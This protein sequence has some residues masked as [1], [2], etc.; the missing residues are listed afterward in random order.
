MV[1]PA[2]DREALEQAIAR[3][4]ELL[5]Q[6]QLDQAQRAFRA[7]LE[8][9]PDNARVLALLGLSHFRAGEFGDARPIYEDL[10]DR[11]PTDASH[12]LNL[13][14]VYLKLSDSDRAIDALEASRA[15][16]PS[17]GRAV[18]Y[19]GLAY[20]RAGRY[21]EAYRSFLLAGQNDLASEIEGN[22]TAAE[23]DGIHGQ[24]GRTPAGPLAEVAVPRT[25]TPPPMAGSGPIPIPGRTPT[26][27]PSAGSGPIPVAARTI[28]PHVIARTPT[29][30]HGSAP[31]NTPGNT[32]GEPRTRPPR[33][34]PKTTDRHDL[35]EL[36]ARSRPSEPQLSHPEITI[37]ESSGPRAL[38][39]AATPEAIGHD[40]PTTPSNVRGAPRVTDSVQFV[41]P[42]ASA[43]PQ[44]VAGQS[45]L[46]MAV[47]AAEPLAAV[48]TARTASGGIPPRPLSEI[49]TEELVRPDDG[50]D[51]FEI[52]AGGALVIRVTDRVLTRLDGVHVTG[53][54]L[55]YEPAMRRSR[56]HQTDERFDFGTSP[57]HVVSG[58]G[59]LIAARGARDFT[60]IAL[61]DD[62]LY[63]REDLVFAFEAGLRWENGNVPGLRGRLHVVQFRGDGAL[64]LRLARPLVRVK[65]PAQGLVFVDA[66]RLAGWI[67]RVIPRAVV[68]PGGGPLGTMCVE[69]TGEG[70]VL[71]EPAPEAGVPAAAPPP[72]PEPPP[73]PAV[74][75]A[76]PTPSIPPELADFAAGLA[77]DDEI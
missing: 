68:P 38:A 66:E 34:A 71:V 56:G 74:E 69:C 62:I 70:V 20:A 43:V 25:M 11:A 54:D 60:A 18:S 27:P 77:H 65:L 53:G 52:A 48:T 1:I 10:V 42:K 40:T 47:A 26:P 75:E 67:G 44:P 19:L 3:G 12:R 36:A 41:L 2:R 61:D 13:G 50:A 4:S 55:A 6:S 35:S 45:M 46:S 30:Q 7:A 29:P 39:D 33:P 31:G 76:T 63:V 49:A 72:A 16:D 57:L 9:D 73:A 51:P 58:K 17:Q 5:K 23:R 28:T 21:A 24:L 59:Y 15:L 22:L 37:V 64:V 14:L 32:I 8:I